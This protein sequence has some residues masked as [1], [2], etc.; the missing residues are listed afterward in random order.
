MRQ[1]FFVSALLCSVFSV[2]AVWDEPT[3]VSHLTRK[4]VTWSDKHYGQWCRNYET[5]VHRQCPQA[6][7]AHW[8]T[9]CGPEGTDCC[10]GIQPWVYVVGGALLSVA[11]VTS[12]FYALLQLNLVFP[13]KEKHCDTSYEIVNRI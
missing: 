6:S 4:P 9:C 7:F 10:F 3:P 2:S 11:F 12:I 5:N 1:W 8:Y 13:Q